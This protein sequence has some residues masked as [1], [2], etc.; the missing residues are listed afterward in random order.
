MTEHAIPLADAYRG[1]MRQLAA[2]VCL[3]TV[4]HQGQ[5]GGMIATAVT[6]LSAEP[7]TL[8]V[9]I[10][11][12]ASM[13]AML[14]ESGQFSVNVL[15]ADALA[16]VEMF[17]SSARR[18]ERF[19]SGQ[20]HTGANG[21]PLCADSLVTFECRLAQTVDWQTHAIFLGEVT[22]VRH[23]RSN[24]APLVYY[25]REFHQLVDIVR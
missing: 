4:N 11:R 12:N 13:F 25:D 6:S 10:N 22:E 18:H 9:C 21:A 16:L 3:I 15:A 17:S 23:P 14:I 7:P 1:G 19:N 5:P 2:G 8:L 24:V 20:W